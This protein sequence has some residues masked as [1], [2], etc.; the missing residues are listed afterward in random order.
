MS[1]FVKTPALIHVNY[2]DGVYSLTYRWYVA[3]EDLLGGQ[4]VALVDF[5]C[6]LQT[7]QRE[8]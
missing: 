2:N 4:D 5:R 3:L 6:H 7:H 8:F 1:G